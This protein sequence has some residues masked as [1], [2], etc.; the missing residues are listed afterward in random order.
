MAENFDVGTGSEN[1]LDL[2]TVISRVGSNEPNFLM[3][4][5]GDERKLAQA[6][7]ESGCYN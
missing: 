2:C 5:L 3:P 4:N 7:L 1:E 6:E